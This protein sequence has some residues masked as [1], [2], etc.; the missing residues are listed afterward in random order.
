M[1]KD[2]YEHWLRSNFEQ[3]TVS[4]QLSQARRI[5]DAYGNLDRHFDHDGF[6]QILRELEYTKTDERENRSNPSKITFET[7]NLY[8]GLAHLRSALTGFYTDFRNAED[9]VVDDVRQPS[10]TA[11]AGRIPDIWLRAFY[12][13]D[14]SADGYIGW[15]KE[16][17][18][19]WFS[20]NATAGDLFL[21]YGAESPET[22]SLN[23]R[24]LL[25]FLQ[26]GLDAIRDNDKCSDEG[27]QRKIEKGWGEKWTHALPVRRA[28]RIDR[29]IEVFHLLQD[30]YDPKQARFMGREKAKLTDDEVSAVL[31]LPVTEVNVWGEPKVADQNKDVITFEKVFRPS[32]GITPSFGSRKSVYEDGEHWPYMMRYNGDVAAFLGREKHSVIRKALI[33]IGYSNDVKRRLGEVNNGIPPKASH[34]WKIAIKSKAYLTADAAKHAEDFLKNIFEENFESLGAEFFIGDEMRLQSQFACAPSAAEF[35]IKARTN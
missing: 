34:R 31:Q 15:T 30:T 1:Q 18:R 9:E 32:R 24:Q 16:T 6:K 27:R 5:E 13:F 10:S 3:N 25:G 17:E 33:K 20:K 21:I 22:D 11:K 7:D 8:D 14:P 12:G 19:N 29:R 23:K 35:T 28:W 26:V 2:K 4:T